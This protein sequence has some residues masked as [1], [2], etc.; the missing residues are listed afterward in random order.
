MDNDKCVLGAENKTNLENLTKALDEFKVEV[1]TSVAGISDNIEKLANCWS[2]RLPLWA[3][4]LVSG[5]F[6]V[7]G[8]LVTVIVHGG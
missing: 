5:L 3:T 4:F 1:R 2:K 7:I 8:I 6:T